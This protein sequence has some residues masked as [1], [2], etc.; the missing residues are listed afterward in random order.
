MRQGAYLIIII[1]MIVLCRCNRHQLFSSSLDRADSL[2]RTNPDSAFYVLQ[3]MGKD[4]EE[5]SK[6][7]RMRYLLLWAQSRNKTFLPLPS[8]DTLQTLL[9]Y[10]DD[11]DNNRMTALYMMGC[12]YRDSNNVYKTLQYLSDA[13]V[14]ADTTDSNC[15][16]YTLSRIYS[17]MSALFHRQKAPRFELEYSKLAERMAWKAK[18]TL[19]AVTEVRFRS[20]AYQM[21]NDTDSVYLICKRAERVYSYMGLDKEAARTMPSLIDIYLSR[22]SLLQAKAAIDRY[23]KFSGF[24]NGKNEIRRGLEN[25][26]GLKGRYYFQIGIIDSAMFFYRKMLCYPDKIN[27][28]KDGYNGLVD[29]FRNQGNKDSLAKYSNLASIVADSIKRLY[30]PENLALS[31]TNYYADRSN[32]MAINSRADKLIYAWGIFIA[33]LLFLAIG[34]IIF[35]FYRNKLNA[36]QKVINTEKRQIKLLEERCAKAKTEYKTMANKYNQDLKIKTDEISELERMIYVIQKRMEIQS[37]D[38]TTLLAN[39][40]SLNLQLKALLTKLNK[41]SHKARAATKEDLL[42]LRY[43]TSECASEFFN[44]ISSPQYDLSDRE[45]LICTFIRYDFKPAE[46]SIMLGVSPQITS[47][48]RARIN[49]RLFGISGTRHLDDNIKKLK[50]YGV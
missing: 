47:N 35:R 36:H 24:F 49:M 41:D 13:A 5:A 16:F 6:P 44:H 39:T 26:Y 21:L 27:N 14:I 31:H 46:I 38:N 18:D 19:G 34:Y 37:E 1:L 15:D 11:D 50:S 23:E 9:D 40:D 32:E 7:L 20:W 2:L 17:Q 12:L 30:S 4:I 42:K 3:N 22:D 45:I 33:F 48:L 25:Y 29:I 28:L 8:R 43:L 10:Y